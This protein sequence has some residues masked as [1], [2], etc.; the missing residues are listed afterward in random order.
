M[1]LA[2][3]GYGKMGK[4]IQRLASNY[5]FLETVI[6]DNE[7]DWLDKQDELKTCA[8]AIEFSTPEVA[9]SN[10][11]S[12]FDLNLP[13]VT[14]T[15]G[16]H[17]ALKEI[18]EICTN[19]SKSFIYG[20][21]FSIGANLYFKINEQIALL[22]NENPQYQILIEETHHIQKK[23]APSG[24]ALTLK[25]RISK[26]YKLQSEIPI[27]SHRVGEAIGEHTVFYRSNEDEISVTHRA[28]NRDAFAHGA[29]KAAKW[30]LRNKGFYEFSTIFE[31]V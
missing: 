16:W 31:V 28:E 18:F 1:K 25:E 12:C 8:V 14:G 30:L 9:L 24:T 6:I 2:I 11:K 15:T 3:I 4:S 23:D 22:M 20:S 27:I 21:N 7:V 26:L 29:L 10:Y 5:G 19:S 17:F 13:I